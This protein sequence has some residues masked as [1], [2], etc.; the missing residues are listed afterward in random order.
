MSQLKPLQ[1]TAAAPLPPAAP[2]STLRGARLAKASAARTPPPFSSSSWLK[3]FEAPAAVQADGVTMSRCFV[4]RHFPPVSSTLALQWQARDCGRVQG[5]SSNWSRNTTRQQ[6]L[7]N[8]KSQSARAEAL[9]PSFVCSYFSVSQVGHVC[10]GQPAPQRWC[11]WLSCRLK[12]CLQ[13]ITLQPPA[14]APEG[15]SVASPGK[16]GATRQ[17]KHLI[18]PHSGN[19]RLRAPRSAL[20]GAGPGRLTSAA[21]APSAECCPAL[22]FEH[23]GAVWLVRN[24][25]PFGIV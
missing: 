4:S 11:C 3:Y 1:G 17:T 9:R 25:H 7:H 21:W 24:R 23:S 2:R 8:A 14:P 22:A 18:Q 16:H 6:P 19:R 10:V 20:P 5:V 12:L 13:S 15:G